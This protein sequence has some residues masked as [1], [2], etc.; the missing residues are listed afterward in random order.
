[1]GVLASRSPHRPNP[2][3]LSAVKLDR[4][5]FDHPDGARLYVSGVDIL[6]QSPILDIKPYLPYADHIPGAKAGWAEDPIER[7]DVHFE[8]AALAQIQAAQAAQTVSSGAGDLLALIQE[9]L[10]IDPRPAFQKRRSPI[11]EPA[12]EGERYGIAISGFDVKWMIK[13]GEIWVTGLEKL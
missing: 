8:P 11:G 12:S 13:D 6:D 1:M 10:T 3:G 9:M 4:I 7:Y 5:D 2:I